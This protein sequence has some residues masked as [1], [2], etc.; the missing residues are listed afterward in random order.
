MTDLLRWHDLECGRYEADL[1]LWR[2]LAATAGGEVLDVGS[3]AGRVALDLARHGHP[4][5]AL[6]RE[7]VLLD[8]LRARAGD[9]PVETVLADARDFD[10]GRRFALCVMPMQTIQILGGAE[11]RARSLRAA[12]RHLEPGALLAAALAEALEGIEPGRSEP[13]DPDVVEEDGVVYRSHPV[14]VRVM[15]ASVAIE[16][17]RETV[18]ADGRRAA[19]DDV[20]HLDRITAEEL[21]EEGLAAGFAVADRRHVDPT[22]EHVGSEVVVL[23]A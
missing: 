20:I 8:A 1:P 19:E 15:G 16:R 4:V 3:G 17:M 5:T 13:L 12:H 6:D 22:D 10:L 11:A 9:L 21:E 23:R 14:G 18:Y 2:E 7:P